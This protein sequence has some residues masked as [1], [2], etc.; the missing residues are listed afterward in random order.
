LFFRVA[1]LIAVASA[2]AALGLVAPLA[3]ADPTDDQRF[4]EMMQK[5]GIG[6]DADALLKCSPVL[7]QRDR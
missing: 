4:L 6:G 2:T 7:H 3:H 5:S 1:T